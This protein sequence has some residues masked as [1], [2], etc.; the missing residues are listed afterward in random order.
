M[1]DT[2]FIKGQEWF[3]CEHYQDG[4][5]VECLEC[6]ENGAD[7]FIVVA[8]GKDITI[9]NISGNTVDKLPVAK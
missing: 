8:V 4:R 5:T 7:E 9:T 3:F 2:N 1:S 6:N